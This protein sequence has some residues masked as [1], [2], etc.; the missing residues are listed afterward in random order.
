[1]VPQ[2]PRPCRNR[3]V[4]LHRVDQS[5]LQVVDVHL[6][7]RQ[8]SRLSPV[9]LPVRVVTR[10][11]GVPCDDRLNLHFCDGAP[12]HALAVDHPVCVVVGASVQGLA[13]E[14]DRLDQCLSA[15]CVHLLGVVLSS[16]DLHLHLLGQGSDLHV[17]VSELAPL[18]PVLHGC[19]RSHQRAPL[20]ERDGD[21]REHSLDGQADAPDHEDHSSDDHQ[22]F[23]G[24]HHSVDE[25]KES[26]QGNGAA[27]DQ[28]HQVVHRSD[29]RLVHEG[30]SEESAH[31]RDDQ[32]ETSHA[33][34][35]RGGRSGR[36]AEETDHQAEKD[37]SNPAADP[38]VRVP[39]AVEEQRQ[40]PACQRTLQLLSVHVDL[41]ERDRL[42]LCQ[43]SP[44]LLLNNRTPECI[45]GSDLHVLIV[46]VLPGSHQFVCRLRPDLQILHLVTVRR[47][48]LLRVN[49]ACHLCSASHH[50]VQTGERLRSEEKIEP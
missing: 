20:S 14:S 35:D 50:L 15:V 43:P 4:D 22:G 7:R 46:P 18:L 40:L 27:R 48:L 30:Q 9:G 19:S 42:V 23:R 39:H 36:T 45:T 47:P 2:R 44:T 1:M 12:G 28:N 21:G 3:S 17:S 11:L 26:S 8:V 37:P 10:L 38:T 16:R 13:G 31:H 32:G 49:H 24:G 33:R 25:G 5:V 41:Q 6:H 29:A 34:S